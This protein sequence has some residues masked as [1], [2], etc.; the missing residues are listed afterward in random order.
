MHNKNNEIQEIE[1]A[2]IDKYYD[3][4][5]NNAITADRTHDTSS[6]F[7]EKLKLSMDTMDRFSNDPYD[8]D[9]NILKIISEGEAIRNKNKQ[10]S[11]FLIFICLSLFLLSTV[12][13]ITLIFSEMFFIYLQLF[14]FIALPFSLIPFAIFSKR[15]GASL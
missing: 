3:M 8:L 7:E 13:F 5:V 1:K 11:E 10:T 2:V 12:I 4:R 6:Q 9:V 15:K 14:S